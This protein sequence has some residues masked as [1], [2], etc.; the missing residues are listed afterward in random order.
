MGDPYTQHNL[1]KPISSKFINAL[2]II[3][4]TFGAISGLLNST[5]GLKLHIPFIE[6][7]SLSFKGLKSGY[8]WQIVTFIFVPKIEGSLS[9]YFLFTLILDLY[10]LRIIGGKLHSIMGTKKTLKL[11][12]IPPILAA[13]GSCL[14]YNMLGNNIHLFGLN[15]SIISLVI[16]FCF[17]NPRSQFAFTQAH[18]VRAKWVGLGLMALYIFQDLANADFPALLTYFNLI[19]LTYFYL[20]IVEKI[21]SPLSF[22]QWFENI[23]VKNKDYKSNSKITPLYDAMTHKSSFFKKLKSRFKRR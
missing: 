21:K 9:P 4:I 12:L 2:V 7:F 11:F 6:I 19:I 23:F 13:L 17:V 15:Y 22:M 20:L 5:L 16:A 8:I 1:N 10:L 18:S 14:T 3:S